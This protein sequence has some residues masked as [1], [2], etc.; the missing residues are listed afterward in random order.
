MMVVL[1]IYRRI[2]TEPIG[3]EASFEVISTHIKLLDYS[4]SLL[5]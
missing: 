4:L 2:V 3:R 5:L 1:E